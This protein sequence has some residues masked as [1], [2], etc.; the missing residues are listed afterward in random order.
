MAL[1]LREALVM[2]KSTRKLVLRT[3]T[4]SALSHEALGG[5][6]AGFIMRDTVIVRTSNPF[7]P[8]ATVGC[9]ETPDRDQVPT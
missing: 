3:E 4:I 5:V 2:T 6:M 7:A 8:G 1:R 9:P